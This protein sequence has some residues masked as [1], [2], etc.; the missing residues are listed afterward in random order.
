[1]GDVL[2]LPMA[3]RGELGGFVL[4]GPRPDG[5]AYRPDQIDVLESAAREVGLDFYALDLA[6][7]QSEV[8]NERRTAEVLRA[9]LRTAVA[10]TETFLSKRS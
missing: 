10:M 8:D 7:L 3:H 9:Q 4:L 2:A 5:D 6:K 1:M